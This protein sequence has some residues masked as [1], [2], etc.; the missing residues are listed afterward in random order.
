MR[1]PSD[2]DVTKAPPSE[3]EG[4]VLQFRR[5]GSLFAR[6]R[7]QPSPV[8]NLE[9]YE[10]TEAED[11]YRHRMIMNGLGLLVT[12]LLIAGGIWIANGLAQL[13]N[14]QDCMM[15]GRRDCSPIN[16]LVGPRG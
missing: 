15:S 6:N 16:V 14:N 4:R 9:K 5:R 13:R 3:P 10:H 7:P 1:K 8:E 2:I 11:D 12:I